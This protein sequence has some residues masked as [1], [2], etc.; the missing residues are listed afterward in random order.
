MIVRYS[1]NPH[2]TRS[3]STRE[4]KDRSPGDRKMTSDRSAPNAAAGVA[5]RIA[6][7]LAHVAA[8]LRRYWRAR[9]AYDAF[10]RMDRRMLADIGVQRAGM[11]VVACGEDGPEL[12]AANGNRPQRPPAAERDIA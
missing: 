7:P 10:R 8:R 5:G 6:G 11:F 2:S 9:R 4:R 1:L 3:I 12:R